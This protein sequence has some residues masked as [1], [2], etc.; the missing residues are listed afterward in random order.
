MSLSYTLKESI[1]GFKRAKLSTFI[2][3]ITISI[4]LL[5]LG[6]FAVVTINTSRFIDSL[7]NA[8]EMEAFL[9]EP[10]TRDEITALQKRV[11]AIEGVARVVYVSKEEAAKIFKEEFGEDINTVI[12]FNP[13]PPSFKIFLSNTHKT[14]VQA[15]AVYDKLV[16]TEGIESVLYRKALL[17]FI[18]QKTA[19]VHNVTLGLGILISL[20]AIF[21]VSN[22]IRLAIYA[23]RRLLRTMALVGATAG[24]IRIPFL[25]EGVIQGFFGGLLASG[26]LYLLLEYSS[27]LLSIEFTEFIH[28]EPVYYLSVLGCGI[29]LGLVG[30]IIS[31]ARFIRIAETA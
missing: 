21:L 28:M 3:I 31:V 24:F 16:A 23:K 30:S 14:V 12:D 10:L 6:V 20:S 13:L 26:V 25:L 5:L 11:T 7:R 8:V 29:V 1:S 27:R 9:Q 4:S 19:T 17:E 18:D 15:N 22:T 2:S